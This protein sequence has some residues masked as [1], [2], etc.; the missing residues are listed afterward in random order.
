M[1]TT[2]HSSRPPARPASIRVSAAI[3]ALS[4]TIFGWTWPTSAQANVQTLRYDLPGAE[5]HIFNLEILQDFGFPVE[6]AQIVK[7]RFHLVFHTQTS[8]GQFPAQDI[9]LELQPPIPSPVPGSPKLLTETFTG[10]DDFGWSGNGTFTFGGETD[11]LNGVALPA[12]PGSFSLLYAIRTFNARRLADPGDL[13]PLG[14]QFVDSW[15]EVDFV[16]V[17]EPSSALVAAATGIVVARRGPRRERRSRETFPRQRN[18]EGGG[19]PEGL[20]R[21][22]PDR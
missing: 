20:E 6:P 11:L 15:V 7:T 13:T 2:R 5:L 14:G 12:P 17:P 16:F 9:A 18:G 8:A 1:R 22:A 3:L 19:A 10:G 4:F 21:G